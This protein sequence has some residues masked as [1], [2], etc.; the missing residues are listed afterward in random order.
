MSIDQAIN[1]YETLVKYRYHP[2]LVELTEEETDHYDR[3]SGEIARLYG[4]SQDSWGN[5]EVAAEM[6]LLERSN[7]LKHAA[8]KV[9]A[10]RRVVSEL[11]ERKYMLVYTAEGTGPVRED[12]RQDDELLEVLRDLDVDARTFN[13][14]Q[15][16]AARVF[17]QEELDQGRCDCLVAMKCLDEGIDIP[18]ARIGL[19]VASTTNP[20]QYVQRRGRIL[21]KPKSAASTKDSADLYDFIVKPPRVLGDADRFIMERKL[22][23]RELMRALELAG[24]ARN[25]NQAQGELEELIA[26]YQLDDLRPEA[27]DD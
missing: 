13:G 3:L 5:F 17:L 11:D 6:K 9:P 12:I 25:K 2:V 15:V 7:I 10:F 23:A 14:D 21:R 18:E 4:M 26:Y 22:V 1:E 27:E 24:S 8:G 20:R 16:L 19:F